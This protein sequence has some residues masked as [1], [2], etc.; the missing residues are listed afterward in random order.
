MKYHLEVKPAE[1]N[2]YNPHFKSKYADLTSVLEAC[3]VPL[4]NQGLC[5]MQTT[6]IRSEGR[7]VLIT[8]MYHVSGQWRQCIYPVKPVKEDPQGYGT[9]MTYARRYSI[10]TIAGVAIEDDDGNNASG[11]NGKSGN[12]KNTTPLVKPASTIDYTIIGRTQQSELFVVMK[13]SEKTNEELLKY[14]KT[15]YGIEK[16][17]YIKREWFNDILDWIKSEPKKKESK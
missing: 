15:N 6:D 16:S 3:R 4:A 17:A 8:R 10:A 2:G 11:K 12:D 1:L 13:D 14:L 5:I 9:A 7:L